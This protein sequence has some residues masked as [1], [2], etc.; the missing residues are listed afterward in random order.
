MREVHIALGLIQKGDKFLL[1][2]R[3]GE[4]KVGAAGLI[5]CFGGKIDDGEDP[6]DT[7]CREIFEETT[8]KP[9]PGTIKKIGIVKVQSDHNLEPVQ[10][11]GHVFQWRMPNPKLPKIKEGKL[12]VMTKAEVLANL[13]RFTPATRA[14]FEELSW[15]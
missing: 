14:I 15:H 1:Q 5:G 9:T 4:A 11:T 6:A 8:L 13:G 10:V 3:D 12:I 7:F 2:L